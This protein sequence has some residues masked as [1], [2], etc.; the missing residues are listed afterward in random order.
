MLKSYSWLRVPWSQSFLTP[1]RGE[2]LDA[3]VLVPCCVYCLTKYGS[4]LTELKIFRKV[5]CGFYRHIDP[6]FQSQDMLYLTSK[7]LQ[8]LSL[9]FVFIDLLSCST[10]QLCIHRASSFCSTFFPLYTPPHTVLSIWY[11]ITNLVPLNKLKYVPITVDIF[12]IM[13]N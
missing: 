10:L 2:A 7:C 11:M 5:K 6:N 9:F 12:C 13:M 3:C 1:G 4:T 8:F